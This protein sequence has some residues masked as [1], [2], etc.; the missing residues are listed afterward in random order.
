[1]HCI[2]ICETCKH[3]KLT[4]ILVTTMEANPLNG[5]RPVASQQKLLQPWCLAH[6]SPIILAPNMPL[7]E[8]ETYERASGNKAMSS[9]EMIERAAEMEA[10]HDPRSLQ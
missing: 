8:C 6:T 9:L 7:I 2:Y 1:M 10:K 3:A 4:R 5:G